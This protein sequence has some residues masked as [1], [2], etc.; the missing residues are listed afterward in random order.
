MVFWS[1]RPNSVRDLS[2]IFHPK[3][4]FP[5]FVFLTK[6][7]QNGG[8]WNSQISHSNAARQRIPRSSDCRRGWCTYRNTIHSLRRKKICSVRPQLDRFI[9]TLHKRKI[10]LII[11]FLLFFYFLED[12]PP[13]VFFS[14]GFGL[15]GF[16]KF[17][18]IHFTILPWF[19]SLEIY[20][21]SSCPNKFL[22]YFSFL[23]QTQK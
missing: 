5:H 6:L 2:K 8:Q 1:I 4:H 15:S 10:L 23:F 18:C 3:H 20:R 14:S 7:F 11:F 12:F 21:F 13:V 19:C 17:N 16:V 22:Y 9:E